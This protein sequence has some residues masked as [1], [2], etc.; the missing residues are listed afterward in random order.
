MG[1]FK[2]ATLTKQWKTLLGWAGI[3]NA[4]V[5][6]RFQLPKPVT[7]NADHALNLTHA[8]IFC[9]VLLFPSVVSNQETTG[10]ALCARMHACICVLGHT[11]DIT[12]AL[13]T[14]QA[15]RKGEGGSGS[16]GKRK[17]GPSK[18]PCDERTHQVFS[19]FMM[20]IGRC[21]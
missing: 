18:A 5:Q 7:S 14:R 20:H 16:T 3:D 17:T 4:N 6:S 19:A 10:K 13:H 21:L 1:N 8:R 2:K 15:S 9:S 11:H 12:S